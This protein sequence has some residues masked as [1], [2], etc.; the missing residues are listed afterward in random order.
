MTARPATPAGAA[1]GR[2]GTRPG[3]PGRGAQPMTWSTKH[4]RQS[5]PGWNDRITG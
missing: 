3:R 1:A 5:S 4:Q 2:A